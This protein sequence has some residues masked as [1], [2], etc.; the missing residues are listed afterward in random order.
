MEKRPRRSS[1]PHS[2]VSQLKP[3]S[4]PS[5]DL[6][7]CSLLL[8]FIWE[9]QLG[10]RGK[11][12]FLH[13]RG[14]RVSQSRET[15]DLD[16]SPPVFLFS[17]LIL[18]R[19]GHGGVLWQPADL[20]FG[21]LRSESRERTKQNSSVLSKRKLRERELDSWEVSAHGRKLWGFCDENMKLGFETTWSAAP[22]KNI[23][24]RRRDIG[25]SDS[26]VWIRSEGVPEWKVRDV[27]AVTRTVGQMD[28][29]GR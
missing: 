9:S 29:V 15:S 5:L 12:P 27:L 4:P 28:L 2:T 11:R 17:R 1:A 16:F 22:E 25:K 10:F 14:W 26:L 3:W 21:I 23:C 7:L 20:C 24:E 8:L 18:K 19:R 6:S 13:H